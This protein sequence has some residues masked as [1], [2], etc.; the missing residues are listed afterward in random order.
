MN[1]FSGNTL[2]VFLPLRERALGYKKETLSRADA[3]KNCLED[4]ELFTSFHSH[5]LLSLH[6]KPK[7]G[8]SE[9]H[10]F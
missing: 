10:I 4:E 8:K 6:S 7:G 2:H 5:P 3:L 1:L 9:S